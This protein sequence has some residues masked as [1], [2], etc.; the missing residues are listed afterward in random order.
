MYIT[1]KRS[2]MWLYKKFRFFVASAKSK[3]KETKSN[4]KLP[5]MNS[6]TELLVVKGWVSH[7]VIT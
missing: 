1:K 7:Y 2:K 5:S 6:V 4:D 3:Y